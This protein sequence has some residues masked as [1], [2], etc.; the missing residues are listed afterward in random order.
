MPDVTRKPVPFGYSQAPGDRDRNVLFGCFCKGA[1][2]GLAGESRNPYR[3]AALA[4]A[5]GYEPNALAWDR[6][7][8]WAVR[9]LKRTTHPAKLEK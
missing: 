3:S 2:A 8:A 4:T 1:R 5:G 6:G 9:R 7:R